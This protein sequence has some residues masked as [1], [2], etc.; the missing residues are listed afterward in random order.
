MPDGR[1]KRRFRS[2]RRVA[3]TATTDSS[4]KPVQLLD[5]QVRPHAVSLSS[6]SE[7]KNV[8]SDREIEEEAQIF[9]SGLHRRAWHLASVPRRDGPRPGSTAARS[10]VSNDRRSV[11]SGGAGHSGTCDH[12]RGTRLVSARVAKEPRLGKADDELVVGLEEV[13]PPKGGWSGESSDAIDQSSISTTVSLRTSA[14]RSLQRLP[15]IGHRQPGPP[16]HVLHGRG[17]VARQVAPHELNQRIVAVEP[18]TGGDALVKEG[19]LVTVAS[20]RGRRCR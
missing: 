13:R 16:A 3:S 1:E 17:T 11:R 20:L 14:T 7:P 8:Q 4:R 9:R 19:G 6:G 5:A 15:E 2:F 10:C 18:S 12:P